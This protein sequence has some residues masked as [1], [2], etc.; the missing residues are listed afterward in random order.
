MRCKQHRRRFEAIDVIAFLTL[1]M[2]ATCKFGKL[3][4]AEKSKIYAAQ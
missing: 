2:R 1:E 3:L 4:S